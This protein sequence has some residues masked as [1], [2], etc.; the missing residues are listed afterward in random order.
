MEG[1]RQIFNLWRLYE[2][3]S[4][5]RRLYPEVERSDAEPNT[6]N[7][8]RRFSRNRKHMIGTTLFGVFFYVH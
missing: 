6:I 4:M 1:N 7:A 5:Q 8:R 2:T 3:Y